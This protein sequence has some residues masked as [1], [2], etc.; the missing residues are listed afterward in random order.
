MPQVIDTPVG[1]Q[2]SL[3]SLAIEIATR[4]Q[5]KKYRIACIITDK[6]DRILSIG[7]NSYT[8]THPKQ[9]YYASKHG[10]R[11][12][13]IFLHAEMDAIIRC[14][15]KPASIYIARV[16]RNKEPRLAKPC[17]ICMAA[18]KDAGIKRII[19]TNSVDNIQIR[20]I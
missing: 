14:R 19:Y 20:K 16:G 3:I 13:R 18:I 1:N 6:H 5:H 9:A 17:P 15:S 10:G 11:I 7:V 2:L 12:N 4:L 8:K